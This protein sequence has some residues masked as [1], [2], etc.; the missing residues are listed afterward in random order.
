MNENILALQRL[1]MSHPAI[2]FV[3]KGIPTAIGIY[4]PKLYACHYFK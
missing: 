1:V 4:F 2:W 3:V